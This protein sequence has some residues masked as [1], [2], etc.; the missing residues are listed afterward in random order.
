MKKCSIAILFLLMTQFI[1]YSGAG[2]DYEISHE[3]AEESG[4]SG[5]L[6]AILMFG[7]IWVVGTIW[8]KISNHN[9]DRKNNHYCHTSNDHRYGD[10]YL[11][12][13]THFDDFDDFYEYP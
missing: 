5:I 7:T 2:A 10:P 9:E 6:G 13:D 12:D 8:Q 4:G 11:Y 1:A 3:A